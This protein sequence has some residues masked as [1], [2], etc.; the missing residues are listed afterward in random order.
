[1]YKKYRRGANFVD[2]LDTAL[3]VTSV[4]LAATGIGL[5][6]T[7]IAVPIALGLQSGTIGCWLLGAGGKLVGRKLQAKVRKNDL[8]R[9]Q[10]VLRL[11]IIADRIS[12]VLTDD[13][14]TEEEFCLILSEVDKYNQMKAEIRGCQKQRCGLSEDEKNRLFRHARDEAMMTARAKLLEEIQAGT[15]SGT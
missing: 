7:I 2:G 9:G 1:M 8:I 6:S 3:S 13:K 11:N 10:A 15:S 12:T 4:G 14:I 5:L